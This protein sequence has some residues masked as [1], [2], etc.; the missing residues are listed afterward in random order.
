MFPAAPWIE[1]KTISRTEISKA[2]KVSED[3]CK[4]S[5]VEKEYFFHVSDIFFVF[6]VIESLKE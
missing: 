5:E 3:D 6:E 4:G 1:D 2:P